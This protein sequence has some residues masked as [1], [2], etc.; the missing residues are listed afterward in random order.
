MYE[1]RMRR[2]EELNGRNEGRKEGRKE[3]WGVDS[4]VV[5]LPFF[6]KERESARAVDNQFK[7]NGVSRGK[8]CGPVQTVRG[9]SPPRNNQNNQK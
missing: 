7:N 4:L 3:G 8:D 5:L 6:E 1:S 2:A 9:L